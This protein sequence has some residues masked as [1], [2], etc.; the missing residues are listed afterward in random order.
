MP[1]WVYIIYGVVRSIGIEVLGPGGIGVS[2]VGILLEEAAGVRVVV[3]GSEVVQAASIL[4][5]AGVFDIVLDGGLAG[6]QV[7]EGI[8]G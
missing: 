5:G 3:T 7:A 6:L 1:G 8:V 2:L 4:D